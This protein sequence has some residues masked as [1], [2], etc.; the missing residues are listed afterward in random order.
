MRLRA[1][2]ELYRLGRFRWLELPRCCPSRSRRRIPAYAHTIF[3]G[4]VV[5]ADSFDRSPLLYLG[6]Q[7]FDGE[8]LTQLP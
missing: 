1:V 2:Q 4:R 8:C 3:I 7:F 5:H 6:G